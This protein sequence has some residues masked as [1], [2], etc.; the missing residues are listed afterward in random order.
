[1]LLYRLCRHNYITTSAKHNMVLT[2]QHHSLI[3]PL[4]L[5]SSS[6]QPL[7]L[8]LPLLPCRRP[9]WLLLLTCR[10]HP[11]SCCLLRALS[12]EGS[13]QQLLASLQTFEVGCSTGQLLQQ[14]RN[15]S[16]RAMYIFKHRQK[17]KALQWR[18]QYH[19][20]VMSNCRVMHGQT[21]ACCF[22]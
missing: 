10:H 12:A 14:H 4:P 16:S 1:M 7:E 19:S 3:P 5:L 20:T 9:S 8:P 6:H 22:H 13:V 18:L 11:S 2:K 17:T 21:C 15:R